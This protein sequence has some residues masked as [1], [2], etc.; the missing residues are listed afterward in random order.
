MSWLTC[1]SLQP[2]E[3]KTCF[4]T[5]SKLSEQI[6]RVL[7]LILKPWNELLM[8]L[9][10]WTVSALADRASCHTMRVGYLFLMRCSCRTNFVEKHLEVQNRHYEP[11]FV[12]VLFVQRGAWTKSRSKIS[13]GTDCVIAVRQAQGLCWEALSE[14]VQDIEDTSSIEL[15]WHHGA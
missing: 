10:S 2:G 7:Q 6:K 1:S 3:R 8:P 15:D 12:W 14:G 11:L 13:P 4:R 5:C 9:Q